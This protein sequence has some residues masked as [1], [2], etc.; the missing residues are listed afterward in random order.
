LEPLGKLT[1][2]EVRVRF[3]L[4]GLL[5]GRSRKGFGLLRLLRL[6]IRRGDVRRAL[7]L[8]ADLL[9]GL[10]RRCGERSSGHYCSPGFP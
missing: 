4:L 1:L 3:G 6:L 8:R 7:R 9:G 5:S 2:T 10:S